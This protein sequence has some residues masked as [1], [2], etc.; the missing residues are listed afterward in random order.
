MPQG[1]GTYGK[2]VGRPPES[3]DEDFRKYPH[4]GLLKGKSHAEGGVKIEAE[5]GEIIM[6][7]SKNGA[8]DKHED[9]LLALNDNPDDYEIIRKDELAARGGLVEKNSVNRSTLDMVEYI[10][11]HGDLP[12]SDARKR[13]T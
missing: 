8:A 10:N 4:G 13:R 9:G 11:K 12:M 1:K 2:Q 5:G 7:T 6:N 3:Q